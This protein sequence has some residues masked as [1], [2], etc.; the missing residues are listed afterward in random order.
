MA[1]YF[2]FFPKT[3]YSANNQVSSLDT[4]TNITARFSFER[5]LK[6][7]SSIFYSYDIKDGDTPE[8]IARKFYDN[9]ERHWIVLLFNDMIDP[10][11]DWP[12]DERTLNEFIDSK[13][14]Y[15]YNF[16]RTNINY[17]STRILQASVNAPI[18]SSLLKE[19]INGRMLADITNDSSVS[20][21]DSLKMNNY[22]N[23][24]FANSSNTLQED[25]YIRDVLIPT[26]QS[27]HIKYS[28]LYGSPN[29]DSNTSTDL[30]VFDDSTANLTFQS[31][32]GLAWAKTK[33]HS[34]Y[35][36][37]TETTFDKTSIQKIEVDAKTYAND[38]IMQTGTNQ[39]YQLGDNT[40][41]NI[42][43]NKETKTYFDYELEENEKKR[44]IKLVKPEFIPEI[45]K[46]FKKVIKQ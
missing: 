14:N 3:L 41:V 25:T 33:I 27:N 23:N 19:T 12:M 9:S 24:G 22:A 13:Y 20:S 40:S 39:S 35:K 38:T 45:E 8:I 11:F 7:N 37:I 5:T 30:I 16:Y 18:I 17:L 15:H 4:I 29:Y 2:N 6:E 32:R 42:T 21:S 36:V 44:S 1:R 31:G 26:I 28:S 46:E 10:Q 34:F 43:I